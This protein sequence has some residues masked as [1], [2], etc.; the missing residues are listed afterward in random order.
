VGDGDVGYG[1]ASRQAQE[2]VPAGFNPATEAE[3][4]ASQARPGR[5]RRSGSWVEAMPAPGHDTAQNPFQDVMAQRSM[6]T[7]GW[8]PHSVVSLGGAKDRA[9]VA[10]HGRGIGGQHAEAEAVAEAG[11]DFPALEFKSP[12]AWKSVQPGRG[13]VAGAPEQAR[14]RAPPLHAAGIVG[15]VECVKTGLSLVPCEDALGLGD[16]AQALGG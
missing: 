9:T 7:E 3:V 14:V 4:P 6:C 16:V 2:D 12:S 13:G 5:R 1:D 15:F 11:A 8:A 10:L